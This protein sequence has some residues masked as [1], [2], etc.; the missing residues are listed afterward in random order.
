[1]NESKKGTLATGII[2][3]LL[4]AAF[5][6]INLVPGMTGGKTWPFIFIV[7][8]IGFL[9]P[10]MIWPNAR[11]GLA[12]LYIPGMIFIVLGGIFLFNVLSGAW[13]V[14]AYAWILIPAAV[15]LGLYTGALIGKWHD[16]VR[17]TGIW[18]MVISVS[19]FALFAALF[20]NTLVK[21][22]GA[23]FLILIGIVIVLRALLKKQPAA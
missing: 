14:W 16:D 11:E 18:M 8:G 17:K 9:L 20:G 7:A 5:I 21:A 10:A 22:I 15:G 4:G 1:M 13:E 23:G 6:V 3:V 12:G 19:V 2:L